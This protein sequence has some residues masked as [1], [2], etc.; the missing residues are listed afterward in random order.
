MQGKRKLEHIVRKLYEN[1]PQNNTNYRISRQIKCYY[2]SI[3]YIQEYKRTI[4]H[5]KEL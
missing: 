1:L 3:Q 5:G 4:E 2:N